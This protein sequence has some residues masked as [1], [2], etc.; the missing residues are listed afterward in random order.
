MAGRGSRQLPAV[1]PQQPAVMSKQQQQQQQLAAVLPGRS[2]LRQSTIGSG[3]VARRELP[4]PGTTIGF[5][6]VW[7]W[8]V[9]FWINR[10]APNFLHNLI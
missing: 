4:R 10:I 1:G 6:F 5:R 8:L 7:F 3:G 9:V 2:V